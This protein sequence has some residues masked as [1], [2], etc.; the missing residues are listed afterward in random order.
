MSPSVAVVD[1]GIGNLFSAVQGIAR[2]GAS[3]ELTADPSRIAKADGVVLPGVGH[4]GSC[5]KAIRSAGLEATV[6]EAA[7]SG[8]PF[9]A[10]CVGMQMLYDSSE[11][12]P[13]VTGLSILSGKVIRLRGD[14]KLPHMQWNQIEVPHTDWAAKHAPYSKMYAA[15]PNIPMLEGLDGSWMYFVHSY[16]PDDKTRAVAICRYPT[17]VTAAVAE[18]NIWATQ[19][20]PEKSGPAGQRLLEN[21]VL[22]L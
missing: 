6:R 7:A 5:M 3:S 12:A 17:P 4:F 10:I 21:F 20:H 18:G 22:A 1:Y 2:A 19:F 16:A 11:E 9:L 14:V 15:K 13:D 8:A